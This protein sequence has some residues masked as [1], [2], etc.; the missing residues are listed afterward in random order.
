MIA[1]K[2]GTG[3][4]R[5]PIGRRHQMT[6]VIVNTPCTPLGMPCWPAVGGGFWILNPKFTP[7]LV[8]LI[9]PTASNASPTFVKSGLSCEVMFRTALILGNFATALAMF[10]AELTP[11]SNTSGRATRFGVK[12]SR[13][14][15][16]D[17]LQL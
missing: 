3:A 16:N 6:Q 11:W 15:E 8:S 2:G 12:L 10:P 9:A 1:Q 5:N 4:R 13:G 17:R 7:G 14:K